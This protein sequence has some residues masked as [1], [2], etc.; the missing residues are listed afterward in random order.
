M[1]TYRHVLGA[2]VAAAFSTVLPACSSVDSCKSPNCMTDAKIS[3]NVE[4]QL[5]Q[6]AE[7]RADNFWVQTHNGV[8]YLYGIVDTP[9]ERQTAPS[10]I[11]VKG[12]KAVVN[13][14]STQ[15]N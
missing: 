14:L 10:I 13:N 8:V 9:Y 5:N 1:L 7:F 2:M 4:Q 3:A 15:R 12:I 11:Q 6:N